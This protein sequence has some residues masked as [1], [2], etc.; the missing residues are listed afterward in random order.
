MGRFFKFLKRTAGTFNRKME[1]YQEAITFAEAG[2]QEY[3]QKLL[4][5]EADQ[6]RSGKLLVLGRESVFPREVM[7]YALEMAQR[8]SYDI[9]ALNTAPLSCDTFKL[10]S[11]SQ[12]EL[13]KNFQSL[14]QKN[15]KEFQQEAEKL[16]IAFEHVVRFSEPDE[17]LEEINREYKN[18]EF[19]ISDSQ[20]ASVTRA[21]QE[22]RV[23]EPI[24]VYS[25][26]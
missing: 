3:S 22:E 18:I 16:G 26:V 17:A 25:I 15:V 23:S 6:E 4:E 2:H 19:V 24:Y 1:D 10:F 11:S 7:D 5:T 13:C 8:L 9:L 12:K 20:K 14:S 21:E